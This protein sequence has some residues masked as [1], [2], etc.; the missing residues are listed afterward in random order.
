MLEKFKAFMAKKTKD[1]QKTGYKSP[2]DVQKSGLTSDQPTAKADPTSK[3]PPKSTVKLITKFFE[4]E[5]EKPKAKAPVKTVCADARHQ[6][7]AI[8]LTNR[9]LCVIHEFELNMER[10][11]NHPTISADTKSDIQNYINKNIVTAVWALS[12]AFELL[13]DLP[14][15]QR[16]QSIFNKVCKVGGPG[17]LEDIKRI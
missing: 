7:M 8:D 2:K 1:G 4:A 12:P 3:V 15:A 14:E 6:C 9:L 13:G 17:V 11:G 10:I 16:Y 5:P